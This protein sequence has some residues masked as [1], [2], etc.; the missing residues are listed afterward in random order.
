M[1][2][3]HPRIIPDVVTFL[4]A[5]GKR[6]LAGVNCNAVQNDVSRGVRRCSVVFTLE[7]H[8][9]V[10]VCDNVILAG[11]IQC[12]GGKLEE[13][14]TSKKEIDQLVYVNCWVII[15]CLSVSCTQ[16]NHSRCVV[17]IRSSLQLTSKQ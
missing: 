13:L 11:F 12:N 17:G 7:I 2:Q 14:K 10:N 16:I 3:S 9:H 1:D 4:K 8:I 6:A 5:R 15:H